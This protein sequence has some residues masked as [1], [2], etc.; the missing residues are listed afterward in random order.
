M[1]NQADQYKGRHQQSQL[2]GTILIRSTGELE[3][4]Y[5]DQKGL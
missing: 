3:T 5:I 2:S 1:S 4:D